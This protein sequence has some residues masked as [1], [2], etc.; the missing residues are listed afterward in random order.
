MSRLLLR[1]D[2][3]V[4]DAAVRDAERAAAR[5]GDRHCVPTEAAR[6]REVG[7]AV[8]VEVTGDRALLG[9]RRVDREARDA[10]VRDAEGAVAVRE[11]DRNGG[12]ARATGERDVGLAVAV[13][14]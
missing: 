4:R 3:E 13:E 7:L 11:R 2:R 14:V 1:V 12:P 8:A 10:V 6:E 5:E 9:L